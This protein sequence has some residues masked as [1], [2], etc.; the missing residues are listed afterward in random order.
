MRASFQCYFFQCMF[1]KNSLLFI[2]RNLSQRYLDTL[3]QTAVID[4]LRFLHLFIE[5]FRKDFSLHCPF[6]Y[7]FQVNRSFLCDITR[8][9]TEQPPPKQYRY[10]ATPDLDKARRERFAG[11]DRDRERNDRDKSR[12]RVDR[13][14][15]RGNNV[16][17][18]DRGKVDNRERGQ[19]RSQTNGPS[20]SDNMHWRNHKDARSSSDEESKGDGALR[21]VSYEKKNKDINANDKT[22][23]VK[24]KWGH[25]EERTQDSVKPWE[26]KGVTNG[27]KPRRWDAL[28]D[29][30]K[31]T[32][33]KPW[34]H[35]DQEKPRWDTLNSR[36]K[37]VPEKIWDNKDIAN[38]EKTKWDA[39]ETKDT[40]KLWC[41]KDDWSNK[42][43]VLI[44][45]IK[46]RMQ[47][48]FVG[49]SNE[50]NITQQTTE[51]KWGKDQVNTLAWPLQKE[52][53]ALE[54]I[55]D[56]TK[57][58][59]SSETT[60]N[61]N[62]NAES[63]WE[64]KT[65]TVNQSKKVTKNSIPPATV[66]T[67]FQSSA[68]RFEPSIDGQG[69]AT[70]EKTPVEKSKPAPDTRASK[71]TKK[72]NFESRFLRSPTSRTRTASLAQTDESFTTEDSEIGSQVSD[73]P[74][75]IA[76]LTTI[77]PDA[78]PKDNSMTSKMAN[79]NLYDAMSVTESATTFNLEDSG[80]QS[81]R[82]S[83]T[84]SHSSTRV[85]ATTE[86][87]SKVAS[88]KLEFE[89]T[90]VKTEHPKTSEATKAGIE[91]SKS[92]NVHVPVERAFTPS[93][94]LKNEPKGVASPVSN[95]WNPLPEKKEENILPSNIPTNPVV[96]VVL[97]LVLF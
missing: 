35:K 9:I 31:G 26:C 32:S 50:N 83:G 73:E 91:S 5:L 55:V 37:A 34:D 81:G 49:N 4:M 56:G 21:K 80:F 62:D 6:C 43:P 16:R 27:D 77:Q 7:M 47:E 17:E 74:H 72:E 95:R 61:G 76:P 71:L 82:A 46:E 15:E 78:A 22:A 42:K 84:P 93:M 66:E 44:G 2:Y 58:K 60:R 48:G 39:R 20:R 36:T 10:V 92:A 96:S 45:V 41:P 67:F 57:P 8:H 3:E 28:E 63:P 70:E 40:E 33:E 79:L 59:K 75:S 87:K 85:E 12:D 23:N 14:R 38:G 18:W 97:C 54:T 68:L 52:N 1:V 65:D 69:E 89:Y 30:A 24:K 29:I 86:S 13:D 11:F 51:V 94:P 90:P 53:S 64:E 19:Y 88:A 25:R